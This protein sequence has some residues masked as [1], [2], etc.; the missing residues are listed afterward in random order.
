[1][2]RMGL[3]ILGVVLISSGCTSSGPRFDGIKG[4]FGGSA[5]QFTSYKALSGAEYR[6]SV[7]DQKDATGPYK[8][9]VFRDDTVQGAEAI[10]A[11]TPRVDRDAGEYIDGIVC[12]GKI[13]PAPTPAK[14]SSTYDLLFEGWGYKARCGG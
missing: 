12:K 4:V 7:S 3:A 8:L 10:A 11:A 1:M 9:V 2:K 6:T 5:S 14:G 13:Y